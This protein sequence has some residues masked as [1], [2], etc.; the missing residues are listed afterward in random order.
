MMI[1]IIDHE[2]VD[3]D[4]EAVDLDHGHDLDHGGDHGCSD[5][6]DHHQELHDRSLPLAVDLVQAFSVAVET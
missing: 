4:H 2:A 6:D 5:D 1:M 3:L